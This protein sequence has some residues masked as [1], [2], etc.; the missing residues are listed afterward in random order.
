MPRP[1]RHQ[2]IIVLLVAGAAIVGFA[3][4]ANRSA[5]GNG[6]L[7]TSCWAYE[8]ARAAL[9]P[10]DVRHGCA[11]GGWGELVA[12]GWNSTTPTSGDLPFAACGLGSSQ[13]P[14][15][16]ELRAETV[17][18]TLRPFGAE[19]DRLLR[20]GLPNLRAIRV[21]TAAR[22]ELVLV[23]TEEA[24]GANHAPRAVVDPVSRELRFFLG[25]A[26][27]SPSE[28][29]VEA[30]H[31]AVE[32]Q[33][34]F[35]GSYAATQRV[36]RCFA[37]PLD[38]AAAD[39]C[40]ELL[41]AEQRLG[42][43]VLFEAGAPGGKATHRGMASFVE[44]VA[45]SLGG[46]ASASRA[47]HLGADLRPPAL[48]GLLPLRRDYAAYRGSATRP[49]C[50]EGVRWVVFTRTSDIPHAAAMQLRELAHM[51]NEPRR[52]LAAGRIDDGVNASVA[53]AL[54]DNFVLECEGNNRPTFTAGLQ[55]S[56]LRYVEPR[57]HELPA[58][59]PVL[60]DSVAASAL[61]APSTTAA[62]FVLLDWSGG[63][64]ALATLLLVTSLGLLA[65]RLLVK[66]YGVDRVLRSREQERAA[67]LRRRDGE[68]EPCEEA[69][70]R[71]LG[72]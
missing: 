46:D 44:T 3:E 29:T 58:V 30:A 19:L 25:V 9:P 54:S 37:A 5:L 38:M 17:S 27:R 16:I 43:A 57:D 21:A 63:A 61:L 71:G 18:T 67:I 7:P 48:N 64:L 53:A 51:R 40:S 8:Y 23:A 26:V 35:A 36:A 22:K 70:A 34:L 69:P 56:L 33:L 13:A 52:V 42:I 39:S 60:V 12:G 55:H 4:A 24:P 2:F 11:T 28:H 49:P 6:T 50:T 47:I 31:V 45:A 62:A 65:H 15:A 32:L 20:R 66:A 68:V 59:L 41:A 72:N 1:Y 10:N 14:V